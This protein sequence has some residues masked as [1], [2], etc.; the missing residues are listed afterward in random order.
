MLIIFLRALILYLFTVIALRALGKSQLGQFQPYEFALTVMMADLMATPMGDTQVPLLHGILP[1]A[2]LFVMHGLLTYLC[3]RSG[4]LR[5]LISGR[6]SLVVN[7]GVIDKRALDKLSLS[8]SELLEGMREAG[9]INPEQMGTAIIESDGHL[10]AFS[11]DEPCALPLIMDGRLQRGNLKMTPFDELRLAS[12]LSCYHLSIA[13]VLLMSIDDSG[14]A[15][16]QD[17][18]GSLLNIAIQGNQ[19][20]FSPCE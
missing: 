4:I 18:R 19:E 13:D 8:L 1:A 14:R 15:H 20:V 2:G 11:K 12:L 7:R 10:S 17:M 3:M 5:A 16:I 9:I 6:P